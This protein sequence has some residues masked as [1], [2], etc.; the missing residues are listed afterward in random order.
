[1]TITKPFS[2]VVPFVLA[3]ASIVALP[4]LVSAFV[5]STVRARQASPI[6]CIQQTG[7]L[8]HSGSTLTIN[9]KAVTA[10]FSAADATF[11]NPVNAPGIFK[12]IGGIMTGT[13][14]KLNSPGTGSNPDNYS[15]CTVVSTPN[16]P[17]GAQLTLNS[18]FNAPCGNGFYAQVIC[19]QNAKTQITDGVSALNG[20]FNATDPK[21]HCNVSPNWHPVGIPGV[22][23]SVVKL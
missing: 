12:F 18:T 8:I 1:M 17:L 2:R 21:R 4:Q 5:E 9:A 13:L 10:G 3:I 20:T 11:C 15:I 14:L 7:G 23:G 19:L 16:K 6:G 22:I